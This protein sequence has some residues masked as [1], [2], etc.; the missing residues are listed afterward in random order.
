MLILGSSI[1]K[2]RI[3]SVRR[4]ARVITAKKEGKNLRAAAFR[5]EL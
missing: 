1:G 4:A 2:Y 3:F 5:I